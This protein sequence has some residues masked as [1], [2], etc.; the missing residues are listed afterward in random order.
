MSEIKSALEIALERTQDVEANKE[1][2]E[3]NTF[4]TE[5]KKL[6]SK[7]LSEE[8]VEL[9][10]LLEGFDKKH[11]R[12]V[13]EGAL[14]ALLANLK[15]PA[16]EMSLLQC[17]KAGQGFYALAAD[18]KHLGKLLNQ[19]E[20]FLSDF[21]QE[22]KR[23]ME[24]VEQRFQPILQQK[25]QAMSQQVGARVKIDPAMDPDFQKMLR[26]NMTILED[27]YNQV[28]ARVKQELRR[29]SE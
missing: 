7:F 26:D 1:A 4:I 5:G 8:N 3:A 23:V 16:D 11:L 9:K 21:L 18:G 15:L 25:E 28:L 24:A 13:K 27:R 12:H 14:Q 17:K 6:V 29:M 20:Q 19:M 22:R 10:K 2:L